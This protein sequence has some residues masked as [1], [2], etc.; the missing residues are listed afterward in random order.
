M[1]EIPE[2]ETSYVLDPESPTELARLIEQDRIITKGMGGP[3]AG[4]PSIPLQQVLDVACG[5]GSWALD[6]A[7]DHPEAQ[8]AGIDISRT[9]VAYANA[10]ARTQ[11]LLNASFEVMD[12]T[13]P[14]DFPDNA[15][16]LVNARFLIGVLHRD[17]WPR[18]L[19]EC[20]R[21]VRPGGV[22][23]LTE[24][25]DMGVTSSAAYEQFRHLCARA[26][27]HVGYGF[28]VDGES[29]DLSPMLPRLL[30]AA[31]FHQVHHAAYALEVS[32]ETEYWM[33]FFQYA[34]MT[35]QMVL[36]LL[37]KTGIG[38]QQ[39]VEHLRQQFLSDFQQQA[40]CGMWH[41]MSVWGSKPA[42]DLSS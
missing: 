1:S 25:Q 21:I 37:I 7:F 36:P 41:Y 6:V 14:L 29:I 39:E 35:C 18:F 9:M 17:V 22:L 31:S 2:G 34:N 30:R 27:A 42:E 10:R 40:F 16:D 3:L 28:S 32:A 11:E 19:S 26:I 33:G 15:F 4:L 23:R 38:S 24:V 13:R 8:V 5:P 20:W 12:I